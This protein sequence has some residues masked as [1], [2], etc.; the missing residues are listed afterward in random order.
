MMKHSEVT[1]GLWSF[2]ITFYTLPGAAETLLSLQDEYDVDVVLL[3]A[4]LYAVS[5]GTRLSAG[6]IMSI[7]AEIMR[8]RETAI[9]PLRTIRTRLKLLPEFPADSSV[10]ALRKK[11]KRLELEAEKIEALAIAQLL[12]KYQVTEEPITD[13]GVDSTIAAFFQFI[14]YRSPGNEAAPL[15]A[16]M[17][18]LKNYLRDMNALCAHRPL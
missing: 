6:D 12:K 16:T 7:D 8:F 13:H 11:V 18:P 4:V 17:Q 1:S 5:T 2:M 10:V 14:G 3:L 9:I 15:D